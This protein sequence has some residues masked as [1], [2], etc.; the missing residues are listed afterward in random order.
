M[1]AR[2]KRWL[3]VAGCV[4]YLVSPI[5]LLPEAVLGPLGLP[6]DA[7][8]LVAAAVTALRKPTPAKGAP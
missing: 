7:L 4:I 2:V 3:F 5:D 1:P 8:A 6:D